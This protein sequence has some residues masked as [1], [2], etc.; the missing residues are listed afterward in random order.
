MQCGNVAL[1][2]AVGLDGDE[3]P[4]GTQTFALGL[5]DGKVVGIDLRH[6]HGD[7]VHAPVGGVIGD[8]G[9]LRFGVQ[10]FQRFRLRLAHVDSTEDKIH[11]LFHLIH[12]F[13]GVQKH[14]IRHF[15]GDGGLHNPAVPQSFGIR[16]PG[17]SSGSSQSGH[18]KPGVVFQEGR[19]A[20]A[21]HARCADDSNTI[22]FHCLI[23]PFIFLLAFSFPV[24]EA[25]F[26]DSMKKTG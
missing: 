14:H 22:R 15:C 19:K 17:A 13:G 6:H 24:Y 23:H 16:F 1:Q 2:G 11:Q 5:D 21:Y 26:P 25:G 8:H 10:F 20:L 4:L 9:D 3:A 18:L 12:V 7:V